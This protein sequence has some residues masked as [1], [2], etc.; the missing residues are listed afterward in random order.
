MLLVM[1]LL[2]AVPAAAGIASATP[3]P[4]PPPTITPDT[5]GCPNR[6]APPPA[7]ELAEKFAGRI[8]PPLPVPEEPIGGPAMGSCGVVVPEGA[9]PVPPGIT[10]ASWIVAEVRS[11]QVLAAKD[12]HG[13]HRPASIIKL[14]LALLVA[15]NLS[16]DH[17]VT[18][19]RADVAVPGSSAGIVA[20]GHYT[21]R[22]LMAGLLLQSGN[23]I[24]HALAREMGGVTE[25]VRAMTR[26]ARELGG[27]DTRVATPSGLDGPGM[28]TSA[29]DMALITRAAL[30]EP[31]IART[32]RLQRFRF[33]GGGKRPPYILVND[34]E[35]IGRYRGAVGGKVG[36]TD[37]A[38]HTYVGIA[39]RGG[40]YLLTV[41][42]RGERH[43]LDMWQQGARLLDYG[44]ALP[45]GASVGRLV[46]PGR[47][48]PPADAGLPT[49]LPE[50]TSGLAV[51]RD[52][53]A[54]QMSGSDPGSRA[55]VGWLLVG[56]A[57]AVGLLGLLARRRAS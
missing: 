17:V 20:G 16:P 26:R 28:T 53:A 21:V 14:L 3:A 43:P 24:A 39:E 44:F 55:W 57:A 10:A 47:G 54:D 22:Q 30:H 31:L 41:L 8:P 52:A 15:E 13:R 1:L 49:A 25:T 51:D 27:F 7:P 35:L 36:F 33:P 23:G 37:A 56:A 9:P 50:P 45:P 32:M 42:M 48:P 4:P 29:Y 12:P 40:R 19:T 46:D 6:T 11:G 38:R 5:S 2:G 34:N 18:A